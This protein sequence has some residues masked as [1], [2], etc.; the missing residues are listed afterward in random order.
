M[1]DFPLKWKQRKKT[2]EKENS[3]L[4][5][6]DD[7]DISSVRAC[8]A[9]A[10]YMASGESALPMRPG[11]QIV[12]QVCVDMVAGGLFVGFTLRHQKKVINRSMFVHSLFIKKRDSQSL[13]PARIELEEFLFA[14][15]PQPHRNAHIIFTS[16]A[17]MLRLSPCVRAAPARCECGVRAVIYANDIKMRKALVRCTTIKRERERETTKAGNCA[18]RQQE[19]ERVQI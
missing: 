19:T 16:F 13:P 5:L 12:D 1:F 7:D 8:E 4:T 3:T 9:R 11:R 6:T 17:Y 18:E 15:Q 14:H 10:D 2:C